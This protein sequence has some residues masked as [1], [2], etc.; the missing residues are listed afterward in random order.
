TLP[1]QAIQAAEQGCG[2]ADASGLVRRTIPLAPLLR[3]AQG[4]CPRVPRVRIHRQDLRRSPGA[5]DTRAG[6]GTRRG[7]GKLAAARGAPADAEPVPGPWPAGA[8]A[9]GDLAGPY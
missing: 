1:S 2:R 5:R 9:L 4:E 7:R 3:A 8:A 6:S